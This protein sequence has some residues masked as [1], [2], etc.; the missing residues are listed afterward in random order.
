MELEAGDSPLLPA[1]WKGTG[2]VLETVRK[3]YSISH[4]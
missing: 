4:P 2:E 1:G 3:I